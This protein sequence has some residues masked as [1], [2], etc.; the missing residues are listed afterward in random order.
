MIF[1]LQPALRTSTPRPTAD[2]RTR[3]VRQFLSKKGLFGAVGL[4]DAVVVTCC[5]CRIWPLSQP[6]AGCCCCCCCGCRAADCAGHC[7]GLGNESVSTPRRVSSVSR[8]LSVARKPAAANEEVAGTSGKDVA[9]TVE[10]A[11]WRE[12]MD[13]AD[14]SHGTKLWLKDVSCCCGK[15]IDCRMIGSP[16]APCCRQ[17]G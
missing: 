11:C 12:V 5:C 16:G 7:V 9:G 8:S 13:G 1:K 3:Q 2:T 14:F 10:C 4:I 17:D 15:S 6:S